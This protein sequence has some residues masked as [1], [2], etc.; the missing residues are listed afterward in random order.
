MP[1]WGDAITSV[2]SR[3]TDRILYFLAG[4]SI[5][6][7]KPYGLEGLNLC[8]LKSAQLLQA[9]VSGD[10]E[11]VSFLMGHT[12]GITLKDGQKIMD[13]LPE[14]AQRRVVGQVLI[15]SL[16]RV[17]AAAADNRLDLHAIYAELRNL[18]DGIAAFKDL[19]KSKNILP[20]D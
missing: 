6:T 1:E 4:Y 2:Y 19:P 13:V 5:G 3:Y 18:L 15:E 9:M 8:D 11:K 12:M 16:E 10:R 14:E 20:P 17:K 7:K